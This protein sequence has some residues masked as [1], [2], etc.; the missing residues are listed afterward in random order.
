[1]LLHCFVGFYVTQF[2][3]LKLPVLACRVATVVNVKHD[4]NLY[5]CLLQA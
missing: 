3:R 1:M 4:T 5:R 2:L